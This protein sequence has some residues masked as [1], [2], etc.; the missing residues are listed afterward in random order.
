MLEAELDGNTFLCHS[1]FARV[2]TLKNKKYHY[3]LLL[4][5]S[6]FARVATIMAE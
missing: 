4:C 5:H 3:T 6:A 1:A 2:A